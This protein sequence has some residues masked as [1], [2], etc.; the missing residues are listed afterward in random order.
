MTTLEDPLTQK[1]YEEYMAWCHKWVV[2]ATVY[3]YEDFWR[4]VADDA[5]EK[6]K[7]E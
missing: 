5:K 7:Y 2:P 6:A 4:M 3:S 1:Q